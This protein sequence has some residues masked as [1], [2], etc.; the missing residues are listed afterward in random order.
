M[1]RWRPPAPRS[2]PY[3]TPTGARR[4]KEELTQ[5]WKVERPQVTQTVHEAAKNGD[6]SENGDYIYGKKRLRE[7]DR[8]VRYLSKRLEDV[9]IVDRLPE[10]RSKIFFGAWVTLEDED[11]EERTYQIVGPDEFDLSKGQLSVDSPLARQLLGK[12]VDDEVAV[13]TPEHGELVYWVAAIEYRPYDDPLTSANHQ[14][15]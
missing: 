15:H 4:L 12:R 5:L 2:S 3:I 7:I 14:R 8:R 13:R 9:T 6:R 1:G 10:D 11:G